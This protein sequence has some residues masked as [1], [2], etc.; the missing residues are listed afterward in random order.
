MVTSI[1]CIGASVQ[2]CRI[3]ADPISTRKAA[4]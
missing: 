2:Q 1:D 3:H 4:F